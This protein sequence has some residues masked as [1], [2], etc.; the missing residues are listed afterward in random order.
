MRSILRVTFFAVALTTAAG[1]A[2]AE[3]P[4]FVGWTALLPGL[5]AGY[6]PS[7]E[8]L[9]K[10]GHPQ[11]VDAVIREMT[12]RFEELTDTCDHDAI[13]ALTYLRTTEEYQRAS[14]EPG[15]F[16]DPAFVNHED[17]IFAQYYFDAYDAWHGGAKGEVPG[18]WAIALKA[19]DK[20]QVK[21]IGNVFLGM[22]A[23]IQRD[24]PFVLYSIGLVAPDGTSRKADHDRVDVFLNRIAD[25]VFPE[26]ARRFDPTVDDTNLRGTLDDFLTFQVV[27]V[28]RELAWRHAEALALAPNDAARA[29]VAQQIE[30]YATSQALTLKLLFQYGL[31]S[32]SWARD[33]YCAI[34]KWDE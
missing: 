3:D 22:N 32:N 7:S 29:L 27:A 28:W 9:C 10:K 8:N 11:C 20:R 6:D 23:H 13:F 2:L 16:D 25:E 24:L 1:P 34:H 5:T 18:A 15:F 12:K 14:L 33:A 21:A 17:A 26:I 30:T 4:V 19:A 31:L